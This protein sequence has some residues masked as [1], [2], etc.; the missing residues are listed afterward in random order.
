MSISREQLAP[1]LSPKYLAE[2]ETQVVIDQ[3]DDDP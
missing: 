1:L 3:V 2:L